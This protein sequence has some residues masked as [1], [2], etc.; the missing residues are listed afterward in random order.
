MGKSLKGKELGIGITQR[1]DGLYQARFTNRFGKRETLY[2]KNL[3]NLRTQMRK[4]Q[5]ADD[6]GVNLVKSNMT[7]DEWYKVW[8]TTCKGNCR[9]T[10]IIQYSR[11]YRSV[12]K[13]LGWRKI[14]SLTPLQI[15]E[16]L[17]GLKS[18]QHRRDVK[19]VL[20]N[21]L[22]I[23]QKNDLLIKNP[24]KYVNTRLHNDPKKERRV[25]SIMET[26]LFLEYAKQSWY[27][28]L[29]VVALETGMRIGELGG[30]CWSD[31][32]FKKRF[33]R[34]NRTMCYV[35]G[36]NGYYFEYHIPKTTCGKRLI[37]MTNKCEE[38]LKQQRHNQ[39]EE[40]RRNIEFPNLVFYTKNGRPLQET[41]IIIAIKT[42]LKNMDK[43]DIFVEKFTPHTFRHTFATRA[44]E[45]GMNPKMLQK[46]LGHSTLQMTM[47]LYCHVTDDALFNEMKKM[48]I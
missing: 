15:Q 9:N 28:N 43:N 48:E 8:I 47:D 30:L 26:N 14:Q 31:I 12:K 21:M 10:S 4:A 37:P 33:I 36:E 46:I 44:I 29:F 13:E 40:E 5:T 6:N 18:D 27:Y 34:V 41:S 19:M 25:L 42:I 23:A 32:D 2:D 20:S 22:N 3:N 11:N 16:T 38:A 1:Q 39:Y 7:L 45:N 35:Q 17:N 24:A